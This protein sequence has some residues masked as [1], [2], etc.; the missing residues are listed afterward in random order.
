MSKT[1]DGP[2]EPPKRKLIVKC[3]ADIEPTDFSKL[4][5]IIPGAI[6]FYITH[7]NGVHDEYDLPLDRCRNYKEILG[8]SH[9]LSS[10]IWM[11]KPG[12]LL[13]FIYLAC[14][15]NGIEVPWI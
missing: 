10:K 12:M 14:K 7:S 5:A 4:A 6:R 9:H 13:H 15:A 2:M 3:L 8:W 11:R 1:T